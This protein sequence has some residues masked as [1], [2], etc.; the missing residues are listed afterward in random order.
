[1]DVVNLLL[2]KIE[3]LSM[4]VSRCIKT[5][6]GTQE[7]IKLMEQRI[8]SLELQNGQPTGLKKRRIRVT[9]SVKIQNIKLCKN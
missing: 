6:A 3:A 5:L 2:E 1:M 9:R 4:A 7:N 8:I